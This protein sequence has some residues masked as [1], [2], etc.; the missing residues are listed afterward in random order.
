M[1]A[2]LTVRCARL[3]V[4]AGTLIPV[5]LRIGKFL[6]LRRCVSLSRGLLMFN[7]F[8]CSPTRALRT[9]LGVKVPN[10]FLGGD[11]IHFYFRVDVI[12]LAKV[13]LDALSPCCPTHRD[14][15]YEC[16]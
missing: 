3:I 16:K 14:I 8:V 11:A 6:E 7:S 4:A 9:P 10:M 1:L 13:Y 15:H 5:S 12:M 2:M